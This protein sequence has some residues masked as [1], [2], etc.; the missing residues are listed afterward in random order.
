MPAPSK[1]QR[2]LSDEKLLDWS[3]QGSWLA[4]CWITGY[5]ASAP[6]RVERRLSAPRAQGIEQV[7]LEANLPALPIWASGTPSF[8]SSLGAPRARMRQALGELVEE[9][10]HAREWG[11]GLS[12]LVQGTACFEHGVHLRH[13]HE[14]RKCADTV[15]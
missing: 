9:G 15:T 10:L 11:L 3:R 1:L 7:G 14:V 12:D 13:D 5:G 4:G 8:T 6:S 2:L